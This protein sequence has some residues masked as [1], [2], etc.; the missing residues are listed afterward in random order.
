[1]KIDYDKKKKKRVNGVLVIANIKD[2]IKI[3]LRF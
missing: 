2:T 3:Y 1:M